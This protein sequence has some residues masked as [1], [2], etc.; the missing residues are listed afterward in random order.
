MLDSHAAAVGLTN[1]GRKRLRECDCKQTL[2]HILSPDQPVNPAEDV[3]SPWPSAEQYLE[4]FEKAGQEDY[5]IYNLGVDSRDVPHHPDFIYSSPRS[6][7]Y[8]LKCDRLLGKGSFGFPRTFG[9]K[10]KK[11]GWRKMSFVTQLPKNAPLVQYVTATCYNGVRDPKSGRSKEKVFRMHAVMRMTPKESEDP[12]VLVHIR[13]GGKKRPGVRKPKQNIARHSPPVE[14]LSPPYRYAVPPLCASTSPL[15]K[16]AGLSGKAYQCSRKR[17][18][19][20]EDLS[21]SAQSCL[22]DKFAQFIQLN[23]SSDDD[24]RAMETLLRSKF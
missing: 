19:L 14:Q 3:D 8:F 16:R 15:Q 9:N 2:R 13:S 4:L 18:H 23:C 17:L 7:V 22:K 20:N 10:G 5:P 11:Y 21:S 1:L 12:L 6:C 24:L